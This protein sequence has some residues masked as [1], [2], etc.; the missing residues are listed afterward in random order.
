[1]CHGIA[2]DDLAAEHC[3]LARQLAYC[4]QDLTI[5]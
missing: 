5:A 3:R 4:L 2:G 1:M